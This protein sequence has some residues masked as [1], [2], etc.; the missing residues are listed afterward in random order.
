L[1]VAVVR[2]PG[3]NC[4]GDALKALR[5]I[6]IDAAYAWHTES[7]LDDFD[8]AFI[9]GGFSYGDYLRCG[10][11]A[12]RSPVMGAVQ[13][14]A[15]AGKP[16]LGA[17]NGFQI[18]CEAGLL[19]GALVRNEQERFV[20]RWTD[21]DSEGASRWQPGGPIRLPIAHGEGRYVL[22]PKS[23][24]ALEA[25]GGV[26]FRY[27]ADANGDTPNGAVNRIAGV[28]N[29]AGN[30]LGMMPHPERATR[31]ALGGEDGLRVLRGFFA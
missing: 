24:D 31:V 11:I 27:Q 10:A 8:G 17:C 18:L 6:G 20:C 29:E 3:S 25:R 21:L 13:K 7:S 14:L 4:D 28:T 22:D 16:V 9:P 5:Q 1:R 19:P 12:S 15:T 23:L 30:V 26:A 2:F